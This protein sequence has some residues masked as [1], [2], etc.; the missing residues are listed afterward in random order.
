LKKEVQE[1]VKKRDKEIIEMLRKFRTLDRDQLVELF[2]N[3]LKQPIVV[4]NRVMKRLRMQGHVECDTD[5]TPYRYFPNPPTMRLDSMKMMHF[6]AIA[7]FYIE[8]SKK[9]KISEFE[10]EFRTGTKGSPEVDIFLI[11]RN[12]PLFVEIQ[13]TVKTK[14]VMQ[15]KFERYREYYESNEWQKL[16]WQPEKKKFF[17]LVLLISEHVYTLPA[18]PFKVLQVRNIEELFTKY[19]WAK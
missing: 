18:T 12:I 6:K 14:K 5:S 4:C 8:M 11:W 19:K 9:G 2:F 10:V 1:K 13:R 7:D 17:P 16:H 3:D 15:E